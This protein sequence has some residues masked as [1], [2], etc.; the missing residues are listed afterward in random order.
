MK[1]FNVNVS[2]ELAHGVIS[3]SAFLAT[4]CLGVI[5]IQHLVGTSYTEWVILL[6]KKVFLIAVTLPLSVVG[7]FFFW[8]VIGGFTINGKEF[9]DE[10]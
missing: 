6:A 2:K 1:K 10:L 4:A 5:L 9:N 7:I 8:Y 3:Y